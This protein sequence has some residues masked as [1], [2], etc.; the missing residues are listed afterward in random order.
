MKTS[1]MMAVGESKNIYRKHMR[2][3]IDDNLLFDECDLKMAHEKFLEE[4]L[5]SV[6]R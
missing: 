3:K 5:E 1:H 2:Q 4:A 6:S